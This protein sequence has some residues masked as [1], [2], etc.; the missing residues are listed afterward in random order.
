[1]THNILL[2]IN[3]HFFYTGNN[4]CYMHANVTYFCLLRKAIQQD[5]PRFIPFNVFCHL[6]MYSK[7]YFL[8]SVAY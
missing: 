8:S 7:R 5:I 6:L 1:M 3:L 2:N 4:N